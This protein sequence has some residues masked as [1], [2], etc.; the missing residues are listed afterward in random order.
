MSIRDT[1]GQ[2]RPIHGN[3]AA[4][5]QA[6]SPRRR[7]WLYAGAGVAL[8][9]ITQLAELLYPLALF[10]RAARV[11]I[12]PVMLAILIGITVTMGPFLD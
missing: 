4:S 12:V 8:G 2:D 11:T 10:S 3:A 1:S 6:L 5:A 9:V 7:Q